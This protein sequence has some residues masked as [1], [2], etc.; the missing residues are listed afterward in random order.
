MDIF[1]PQFKAARTDPVEVNFFGTPLQIPRKD[2]EAGVQIA[3][4]AHDS[5]MFHEIL[6]AVTDLD[7]LYLPSEF[8]ELLSHAI[9][10]T[11]G[12]TDRIQAHFK[13]YYDCESQLSAADLTR[14]A[15]VGAVETGAEAALSLLPDVPLQVHKIL[16]SI[17]DFARVHFSMR[18][19]EPENEL[20]CF[21]GQHALRGVRF[22][23]LRFFNTFFESHE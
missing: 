13:S 22:A 21:I 4:I 2:F 14:L 3:S 6:R 20:D 8:R 1:D 9:L 17:E 5:V 15:R 16:S 11:A 12:D 7:E 10:F 19:S 23:A 18:R